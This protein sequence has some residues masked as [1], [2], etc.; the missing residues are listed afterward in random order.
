MRDFLPKP[1]H[2]FGPATRLG[3]LGPAQPHGPGWAQLK[4]SSKIIS[5]KVC[6]FP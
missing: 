6:D 1:G 2:W 5:K 4:K 3:L